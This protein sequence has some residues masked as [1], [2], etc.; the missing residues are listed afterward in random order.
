MWIL[1]KTVDTSQKVSGDRDSLLKP[2][3]YS[4]FLEVYYGIFQLLS[5]FIRLSYHFL[6][7]KDL[8]LS[9]ARLGRNPLADRIFLHNRPDRSRYLVTVAGEF[10]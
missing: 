5:V 1:I 4:Q 2:N 8:R 6:W 10:L 3:I 7:N 9:R